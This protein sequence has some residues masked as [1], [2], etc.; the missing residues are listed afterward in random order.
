MFVYGEPRSAD[1]NSR[2]PARQ[3]ASLHPVFLQKPSN[4]FRMISLAHS[5]AL[6]PIQSYPCMKTRG[7]HPS[8]SS[9]DEKL[10]TATPLDSALTHRDVCKSFR[11]C[12][13]EDCRVSPA[14][15]SQN[16]ILDPVSSTL[17]PRIGHSP[18][19]GFF[20]PQF[21]FNFELS[22]VDLCA[23]FFRIKTEHPS[24]DANPERA[25]RAEG[26]HSIPQ[27]QDH[28]VTHVTYKSCRINTCGVPVSV[29][30]KELIELL[31]PLDA[32]LTQKPGEGGISVF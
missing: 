20:S 23:N 19:R 26:S 14:V 3:T 8:P 12:S 25:S 5:R 4:S 22:T 29:D 21:T 16:L 15:S 30:S 2:C 1:Q 24:K 6:T 18:V 32:T 17:V 31:T 10:V 7:G 13:Y 9:R 11:M 28:N 27:A